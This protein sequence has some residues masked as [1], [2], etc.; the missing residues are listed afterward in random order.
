MGQGG[1]GSEVAAVPRLLDRQ[2]A[3]GH[4]QRDLAYD[5]PQ[6][7]ML[8]QSGNHGYTADR[9]DASR[10]ARIDRYQR[11]GCLLQDAALRAP[12][13]QQVAQSLEQAVD[14]DRLG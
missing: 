4:L 9:I 10:L 11:W 12:P 6:A 5:R 2:H 7:G 13:A 14:V 1:Q 8:S 3:L